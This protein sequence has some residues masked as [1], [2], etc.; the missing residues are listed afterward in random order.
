MIENLSLKSV[1]DWT[2]EDVIAWLCTLGLGEHS[3]KFRQYKV[4][5]R[6]LLSCDRA[7]FT[8]LGVTRIA[9]RQRIERSLKNFIEQ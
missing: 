6:H 3:L 2:T 4:S 9:H 8:Q 5:G 1:L 7:L